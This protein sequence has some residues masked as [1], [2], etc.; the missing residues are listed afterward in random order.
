ME[1]VH[2][3]F[4]WNQFYPLDNDMDIPPLEQDVIPLIL[5]KQIQNE[6]NVIPLI[7]RDFVVF[8]D[9]AKHADN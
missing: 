4:L 5:A 3:L 9:L 1:I 2:K 7:F 6:A 8:L